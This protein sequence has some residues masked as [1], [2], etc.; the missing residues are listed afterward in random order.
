MA[1]V[2]QY[3]TFGDPDVVEVVE[4]PTPHAPTDGVVVEVRAAGIN[5]IDLKLM[6]GLR[7]SSEITEP[8]RVGSDAAGV[9]IDAGPDVTGWT[10]GDEVIVHRARGALATHVVA[11]PNQLD[12]KPAGLSWEQAAA[13]GV[14]VG[15]AYQVLKSLGVKD[16][17]VLL[18]HAGSGA[19]GQ[20]AI[21]F[22]RAWGATVVATGSARSQDRI[23]EL[24]AIPV[25]Y[26]DGLLDRLRA[27][28]P[29][30]Y[31]LILD[32]AG[33]DEALEA[34]FELVDDRQKVGTIVVGARAA[35]LGIRAWAGGSPVPLTAE[36]ERLRREAI[37][38]AAELISEGKFDLEIGATYPLSEAVEALRASKSG[39]IRGK[40][41]VIP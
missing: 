20:A 3:S 22:A 16:G 17:T 26:G 31:D 18:I 27:A 24:G 10:V 14:P 41:V 9:I 35:S 23:R 40:I 29:Q 19:V 30:G 34:S 13:M 7:A 5:P 25:V 32:A 4:V 21:Q 6:S 33:T 36:E 39:A 11:T 15:T 38:V 28:A 1:R 8:R 12:R 37:D 2:A